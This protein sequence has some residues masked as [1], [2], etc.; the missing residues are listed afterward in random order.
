M[1]MAFVNRTGEKISYDCSELIEELEEDI[2]EF[3]GDTAV[4]VWQKEVQGVTLY[5]NYDFIEEEVPLSSFEL[6]E[7]E[8]ITKMTMT[9]LLLLLRQQDDIL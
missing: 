1:C 5:T 2:E 4:A 3:G 9:A 7:G 6:K 8:T